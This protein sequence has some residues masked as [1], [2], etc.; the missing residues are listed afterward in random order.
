MEEIS[1]LVFSRGLSAAEW[2]QVSRKRQL[3]KYLK[4][5]PGVYVPA[6]VFA[7]APPWERHRLGALAVGA[8]GTHILAGISAAALWRMW[9]YIVDDAPVEYYV[10]QGR[11]KPQEVGRRFRGRLPQGHRITGQRATVTSIPR[12]IIDLAR[13]HGFEACFMAMTWAFRNNRCTPE[14]IRSALMPSLV[15]TNLV[16]Q[17]LRAVDSRVESAPEAFL[18]AQ[19]RK[20]GRL[21][22]TPQPS[23]MD[24][25]GTLRRADFQV[26]RTRYLIEVSGL[27]KYGI[28]DDEKNIKLRKEKRRTD[29][30]SNAGY[31]VLNYTA[32]E[33]FSGVAYRDLL[34]RGDQLGF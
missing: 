14:G 31:I 23:I 11:V 5:A 12:T 3:G 4:L 24:S 13:F 27:G 9:V 2:Q 20:D 29:G 10:T 18:L 16:E 26:E 15:A 25:R 21:R 1:G 7:E 8:S 22:L 19:A 33:V 6:G 34:Q 30:L 17:V 28:T 32:W